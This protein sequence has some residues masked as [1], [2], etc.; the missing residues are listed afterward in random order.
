MGT[1]QIKRGTKSALT[2]N[3]PLLLEGQPC[4]ETNTGQ[5]KIGDGVNKYNNLPYVG[6]SSG[7]SIFS[8]TVSTAASTAAKTTTIEDFKL[9]NEVVV[10][11]KFT[12]TNTANNP[13]LNINGTGA[14]SIYYA[15]T[16]FKDLKANHLYIMKYNG[17]QYE[18]VSDIDTA[19]IPISD[20]VSSKI[21]PIGHTATSGNA[22]S[23]GTNP[24]VYMQNETFHV[25]D[26]LEIGN[27]ILTYSSNKLTISFK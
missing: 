14:K 20:K 3:N 15:G 12:V 5:L 18:I 24:N 17:S 13:T 1:I 21:Y 7:A 6:S 8:G 4:F 23:A 10:I 25:G 22:N 27:A 2:T 26:V 16:Y 9:V 11:V 19:V